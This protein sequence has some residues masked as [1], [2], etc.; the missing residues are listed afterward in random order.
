M[1]SRTPVVGGHDT[2]PEATLF[3]QAQAGCHDSLNLLMA[4]HEGLVHAVVR[5]YGFGA[6]AF[7]EALHRGRVGLWRAILHYAPERGVAF[8]SFAWACI[9][10]EFLYMRRADR[11]QEEEPSASWAVLP[12]QSLDFLREVETEGVGPS[13]RQLVQR[14]PERLRYVIVTYYGLEGSSASTYAAIGSTLG[15]T[16]QRVCQLHTEA[17]VWLRQPAHSQALR[18]LLDRHTVVDYAWADDLAQRWLQRRGGRHGR[19]HHGH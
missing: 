4:R 15:L 3:R 11:R 16:K 1:R 18:S 8:A 9:R 6:L 13:L 12:E 2:P 5:R 19:A 17:L 10:N 7:S 14:L